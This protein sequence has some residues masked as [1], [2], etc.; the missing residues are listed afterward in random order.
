MKYENLKRAVTLANEENTIILL[1]SNLSG[2]G[3]KF[4]VIYE[5]ADTEPEASLMSALGIANIYGFR[6]TDV[7]NAL[8]SLEKL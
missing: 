4:L 5:N 2:I 8:G 1:K 3:K 6:L 7:V